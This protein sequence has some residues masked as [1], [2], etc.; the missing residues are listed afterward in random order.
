[1]STAR[2]AIDSDEMGSIV[3]NIPTTVQ[4]KVDIRFR[5]VETPESVEV[6]K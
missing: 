2:L 4:D 6:I 5:R 1:M 3:E